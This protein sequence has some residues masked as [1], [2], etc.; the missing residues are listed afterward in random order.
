MKIKLLSYAVAAALATGAGSAFALAPSATINL[1][2]NISGSSAQDG[3]LEQ[4]FLLSGAGVCAKG[5]A[6]VFHFTGNSNVRITTC[7]LASAAPVPTALQGLNVALRKASNGGS[8]NGV[9]PVA[10]GTGVTQVDMTDPSFLTCPGTYPG[11]GIHTCNATT[12]P[13]LSVVPDAGIS[14][15]EPALFGATSAELGNMFAESQAGV[16]FGIPVTLNLRNALQAAQGI[17][18]IGSDDEAHMPTISKT[19]VSAIF[20]GNVTDWGQVLDKNLNPLTSATGDVHN[21][22]LPIPTNTSVFIDRRVD[23]SGTQHGARVYFLNDPC[24]PSAL[25][26]TAVAQFVL[27]NDGSNATTG[28][29]CNPAGNIGGITSGTVNAGSGGGNVATCLDTNNTDGNWAIGILGLDVEPKIAT[30]NVVTPGD[31]GYRFIKLGGVAPDLLN[32]EEGRYDYYMENSIQWRTGPG[33]VSGAP[34]PTGNTLAMVQL[35]G[36]QE[37]A[38]AVI[39]AIDGTF[40]LNQTPGANTAFM[41]LPTVGTNAPTSLT[42]NTNAAVLANPVATYTKSPSGTTNN[43]QPPVA[44]FPTAPF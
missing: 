1:T 33:L 44:V 5:T 43:C 32:V 27:P 40:L 24:T 26:P 14:D 8:G 30:Q 3:A 23:S 25:Q 11:G 42:A 36:T 28:G 10:D 2:V 34:A 21:A 6:D 37:A 4:M 38:P 13:L 35:I 7:T 15:E 18:P 19:L 41:A 29:T 31:D 12:K 16:I 17:S 39:S 9:Q 22:G 20:S